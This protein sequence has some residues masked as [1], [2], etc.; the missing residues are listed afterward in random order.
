MIGFLEQLLA[1]A[2]TT[3]AE[4]I[5]QQVLLVVLT[6]GTIF[7]ILSNPFSGYTLED[8]QRLFI[9]LGLSTIFV[10]GVVL[11]AFL[12]TSVLNREIE[13]R[14]ALT[15]LSKPVARPTFILGKFVGVSGA[16]LAAVAFL[17]LVF[18]LVEVH[19]TMQTARTPYHLPALTFGISAVALAIAVA[20]GA[21][22]LYGWAFTSTAVLL[23]LP[24]LLLAYVLT[25]LFAHDWAPQAIATEFEP[26]ILL[27]IGGMAMALLMLV[28]VAIAASTR[29]GQLPTLAITMGLFLVGLLSDWL[30]GR[31]ILRLEE[32]FAAAPEAERSLF[33]GAHLLYAGCRVAYAIVP[34]FQVFWIADA[35][36]QKR[37]IP[38]SYFAAVLPYGVLM[39]A[40]SLAIATLLF[41]RRE[42]S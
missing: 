9:D 27:A 4:S 12:A 25:L 30:F 24:L 41:Q 8:D 11:A 26:Q 6:A 38:F 19:V 42:V 35:L 39:I 2:R 37:E 32:G 21:N 29:L 13:N 16:L 7:V 20:A 1:I 22:F 23:G 28:A 5:R 15:V 40:A 10:S 31:T 18:L 34:D 3:F 33:D 14:T 17:G 36:T